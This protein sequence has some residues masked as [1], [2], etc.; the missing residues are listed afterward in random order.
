MLLEAVGT[1]ATRPGILTRPEP[2]TRC[3]TPLSKQD[4]RRRKR[5]ETIRV[6]WELRFR[7]QHLLIV[8][9]EE[10]WDGVEETLEYGPPLTWIG[11]PRGAR[12][13]KVKKEEKEQRELWEG[14]GA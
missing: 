9:A 7:R 5:I 2:T 14:E 10:G 8:L 3:M 6:A 11:R 12:R 1:A 4:R 13:V